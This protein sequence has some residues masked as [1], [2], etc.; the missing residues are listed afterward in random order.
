MI[1]SWR[2]YLLCFWLELLILSLSIGFVIN[3]TPL[4]WLDI[5]WMHLVRSTGVNANAIMDDYLRIINYLQNPFNDRLQF[6]SFKSSLDGLQHFKDVKNLILFNHAFTLFSGLILTLPLI[7][8][9]KQRQG[10]R[11]LVPL[12]VIMILM[13]SLV[14]MA[15]VNF[16]KSFIW[17]NQIL[18]RNQDWIFNP[19]VDPIIKA[20][21]EAFF[22]QSFT[23]VVMLVMIMNGLLFWLSKR[24]LNN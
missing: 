9:F 14:T 24:N 6:Q 7:R 21:P 16:Q 3:F 2:D 5:H 13:A 15:L 22:I 8:L 12:R 23:V 19:N 20:L 10:W 1:S 18:F 17:F 11:L 4:Y